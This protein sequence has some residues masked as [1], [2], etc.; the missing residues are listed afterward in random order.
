LFLVRPR[1]ARVDSKPIRCTVAGFALTALI[2]VALYAIGRLTG[3]WL[4]PVGAVTALPPAISMVGW[5]EIALGIGFADLANPFDR[6][7]ILVK[8]GII[9]VVL[10]LLWLYLWAGIRIANSDELRRHWW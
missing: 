8:A 5:V 3:R 7:G 4:I 2:I 10:S 9:L 6:G 1:G